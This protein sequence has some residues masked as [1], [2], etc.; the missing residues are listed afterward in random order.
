MMN[1]L[2]KL[3]PDITKERKTASFDVEEFAIW[4]NNGKK[5]LAEKRTRGK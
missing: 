2:S 1:D 4:W 5:M 3:N